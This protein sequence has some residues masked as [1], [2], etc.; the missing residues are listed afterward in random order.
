MPPP[1]GGWNARD[2]VDLMPPTDAIRLVNAFPETDAVRIRRGFSSHSTGLGTG[3]V[4]TLAE[5]ANDAGARKL[6]A[7]ANN[8]IYDATAAGAATDITGTTTPTTNKWQ[9]VMFNNILIAVNGQDQP[10][11]YNGT[12]V[13]DATYTGVADDA[14]L[15]HVTVHK[16]RL[17]FVEKNTASFWY[18]ATGAITGALT[19][20]D[21]EEFLTKGGYIQF[22]ATWTRD[23]G[24]GAD[25]FFVVVTNMGEVLVYA[26]SNPGSDFALQGRFYMPI[27]LGRRGFCKLGPDLILLN[28][29]GAIPLSAVMLS[30]NVTTGQAITDKIRRAFNDQSRLLASSFGWEAAVYPRGHYLLI[31]VPVAVGVTSEQYVMNTLTGSWCRFTNQNASSWA[32]LNED[33]YF[34]G[35][36]GTVYKADTGNNDDDGAIPIDIKTAFNYFEDR[37]SLKQFL[38]ARPIVNGNSRF[39]FAFDIDVDFADTSTTQTVSVT[40]D[41]GAP[42]DTSDWDTASWGDDTILMTEWYSVAGLGYSAAVKL[43]GS[44]TDVDFKI[45][46]MNMIY[47]PGG[48]F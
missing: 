22:C 43:K 1:V 7:F 23:A 32:M 26:G 33:L 39:S 12:A 37:S 11:Q 42:W 47:Q 4:E 41:A 2:S 48:L 13:S 31:N 14:T 45:N 10:Q 6:I 36:D 40:S 19:E 20:F 15:V 34:G 38:M 18:G 29:E 25:D 44:F 27:P 35:M 21:V 16:Q 17:Y 3:T 24:D 5:F 30:G 46:S 8:K 9:T 28:E